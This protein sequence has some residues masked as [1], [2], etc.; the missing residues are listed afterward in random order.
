[1]LDQ[2]ILDRS[3]YAPM[4]F[5]SSSE[6]VPIIVAAALDEDGRWVIFD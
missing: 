6:E 2:I 5:S 4:V 3:E 1:M